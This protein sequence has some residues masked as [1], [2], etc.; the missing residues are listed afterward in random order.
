MFSPRDDSNFEDTET[1]NSCEDKRSQYCLFEVV[2]DFKL[3]RK[4]EYLIVIYG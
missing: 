4:S 2:K 1:G 3:S